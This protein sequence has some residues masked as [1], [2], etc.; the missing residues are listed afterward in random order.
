MNTR[1]VSQACQGSALLTETTREAHR[2]MDEVIPKTQLKW[3]MR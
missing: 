1:N 3:L 2:K